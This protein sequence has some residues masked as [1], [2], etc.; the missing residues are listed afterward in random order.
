MSEDTYD[1]DLTPP[2]EPLTILER[3]AVW[4]VELTWAKPD[5]N[6]EPHSEN[7]LWYL[8]N[9]YTENMFEN[10]AIGHLIPDYM[11]NQ[12]TSRDKEAATI[13]INR[14][15][16]PEDINLTRKAWEDELPVYHG[17]AHRHAGPSVNVKM[18]GEWELTRDVEKALD[19]DYEGIDPEYSVFTDVVTWEFDWFKSEFLPRDYPGLDPDQFGLYGRQGG[20]L[21]YN[22]YSSDYDAWPISLDEAEQLRSL[23]SEIPSLVRGVE[24]EVVARLGGY[25]LLKIWDEVVDEWREGEEDAK[26][27]CLRT[28]DFTKAAWHQE[29]LD[30]ETEWFDSTDGQEIVWPIIYKEDE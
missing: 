22:V 23:F 2:P 30:A 10:W 29:N 6:N 3:L 11:D 13:L 27:E 18:N 15:L 8:T 9:T 5:R 19:I 12:L 4:D 14:D 20:H 7:G 24:Q 26:A 16:D 25:V 17:D 28:K 21:V 1:I